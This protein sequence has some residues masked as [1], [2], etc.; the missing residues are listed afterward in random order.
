[1][2]VDPNTAV[3]I[4]TLLVAIV[5]L[6]ISAI[7]YLVKSKRVRTTELYLSGEP[8][9]VVSM[10]TP[11]IAALY[12][13]FMKKFASNLYKALVERVHTGSLH[14]WYKFISSWL[15]LL[16]ILSIALFLAYALSR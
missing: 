2:R 13:G 3:L 6:V 16:L 8:E 15:G 10:V 14:D 9:T 12:W 11:S 1:M 7:Y 4:S 5:S